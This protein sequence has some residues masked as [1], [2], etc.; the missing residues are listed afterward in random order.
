MK[1]RPEMTP[2]AL[3]AWTVS[4]TVARDKYRYTTGPGQ[5]STVVRKAET[6]PAEA[7]T[8]SK[9]AADRQAVH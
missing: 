5:I 4:M 8:P 7:W 2:G 6:G 1:R 9:A 3:V